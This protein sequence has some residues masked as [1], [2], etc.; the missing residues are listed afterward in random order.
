MGIAQ[1]V[2]LDRVEETRT[3]I[4][5]PFG[6]AEGMAQLRALGTLSDNLS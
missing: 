4:E 5:I 6:R 3:L 1:R 2:I